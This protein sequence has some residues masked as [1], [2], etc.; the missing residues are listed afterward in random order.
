M[1]VCVWVCGWVWLWVCVWVGVGVGV[2]VC[3]L[4]V[5][6]KGME[7]EEG[8]AAEWMPL[9]FGSLVKGRY[10]SDRTLPLRVSVLLRLVG[11]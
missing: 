9:S 4:Q 5:K 10:S 3:D 7:L 8:T 1:C 11:W 2:C 6:E